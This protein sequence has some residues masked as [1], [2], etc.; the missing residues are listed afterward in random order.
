MNSQEHDSLTLLYSNDPRRQKLASLRMA[1][2]KVQSSR[3]ANPVDVERETLRLRAEI[4]ALENPT[5]PPPA[6]Q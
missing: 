5:T 2:R 4:D 1:L 3:T 6:H